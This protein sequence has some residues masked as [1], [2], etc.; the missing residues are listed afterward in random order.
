[1]AIAFATSRPSEP[2]AEFRHR[3]SAH[4]HY[5][6]TRGMELV[7]DREAAT[8]LVR[9]LVPVVGRTEIGLLIDSP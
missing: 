4:D 3:L 6:R 9:L 1:M 2:L 8:E 7:L 5:T